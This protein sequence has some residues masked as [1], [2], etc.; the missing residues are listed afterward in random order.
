MKSL[1][2]TI[3]IVHEKNNLDEAIGVIGSD[4]PKGTASAFYNQYSSHEGNRD[5]SARVAAKASR[6]QKI[7]ME[8]KLARLFGKHVAQDEPQ[9]LQGK[10]SI[11]KS[12]REIHHKNDKK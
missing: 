10:D 2:H 8:E 12:K 1:E 9:Q 7:S 5:S 3:R 4:K 11:I 6:A